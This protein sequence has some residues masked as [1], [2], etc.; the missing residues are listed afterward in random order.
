[1]VGK[2]FFYQNS[3]CGIPSCIYLMTSNFDIVLTP[4]DMFSKQWVF[5]LSDVC[6]HNI[7]IH[8]CHLHCIGHM[9]IVVATVTRK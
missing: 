1:M 3:Q 4:V 6:V 2:P 9:Y 8:E 7:I 5:P